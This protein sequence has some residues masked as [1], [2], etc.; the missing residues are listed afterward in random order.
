MYNSKDF[1]ISRISCV[2][3]QRLRNIHPQ[4]CYYGKS[5]TQSFYPSPSNC[6][7]LPAVY[8]Y[9]VAADKDEEV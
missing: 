2:W 1:I 5:E 3:L 7:F 8:M 6:N 4:N 9:I